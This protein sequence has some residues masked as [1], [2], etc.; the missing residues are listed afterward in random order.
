GPAAA[1]EEAAWVDILAQPRPGPEPDAPEEDST[2]RLRRDWLLP[3]LAAAGL[4]AL[5][6]AWLWR[7]PRRAAPPAPHERALGDLRRLEEAVTPDGD[8]AAFHARLSEVL[9]RYLAE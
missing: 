4:A 8:A 6:V 3:A 9:R 7:W 5:G 2:G 1:W